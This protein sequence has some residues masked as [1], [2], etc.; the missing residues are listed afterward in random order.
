VDVIIGETTCDGK[1]KMYEY[2]REFKPTHIMQLPQTNSGTEETLLWQNEV[3]RLKKFLEQAFEVEITGNRLKAAIRQ[4][5]QHRLA[6]QEFF[7]LWRAQ[8]GALRNAEVYSVLAN[9]G[10]RLDQA[11]ALE[12]IY[13]LIQ[14][15]K[16]EP[17]EAYPK[18]P[19]SPRIL[20]TG[21]PLGEKLDSMIN[22][23]EGVGGELVCIENCDWLKGSQDLVNEDT[24]PLSA[25]ADK[26]LQIPCPVMTP[27]NNR[28]ALIARLIDD[29]QIDGVIDF[30]LQACLTYSV[31]TVPMERFVKA[32]NTGYLRLESNLSPA[33]TGQLSTRVGAFIEMLSKRR[34]P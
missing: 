26:Y 31:E 17:Q 5:N 3:L 4:K 22:I 14:V 29:N 2:L 6:L 25:I 34:K 9:F 15:L 21:C 30:V 28:K 23:V 32:K 11:K 19:N 12:D 33:D 18:Q 1:K 24:E 16:N 8:P 27:D 7:T 10:Y 13:V 20:L